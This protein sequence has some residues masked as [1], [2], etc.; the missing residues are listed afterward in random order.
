M[1]SDLIV[2]DELTLDLL[3]EVLARM[4]R[5]SL[6]GADA[7]SAR[8]RKDDPSVPYEGI[9]GRCQ[10]PATAEKHLSRVEHTSDARETVDLDGLPLT[11]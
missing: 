10:D 9:G 11:A 1:T 5:C 8:A 2:Q 6:T 3:A 4:F 7:A